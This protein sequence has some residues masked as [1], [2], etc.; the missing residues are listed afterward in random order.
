MVVRQQSLCDLG[1]TFSFSLTVTLKNR[2]GS[3]Q[4]GFYWAFDLFIRD[5]ASGGK[6]AACH[7]PGPGAIS[8]TDSRWQRNPPK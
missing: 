4:P 8:T 7:G 3:Q 6:T 1:Y 2:T 5:C